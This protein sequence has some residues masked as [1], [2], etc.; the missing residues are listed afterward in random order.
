[1]IERGTT[2]TATKLSESEREREKGIRT[3]KEATL[4]TTTPGKRKYLAYFC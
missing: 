4:A 1:V 3:E 2:V